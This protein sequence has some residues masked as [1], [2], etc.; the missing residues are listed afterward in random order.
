MLTE[1]VISAIILIPIAFALLY[2]GGWWFTALVALFGLIAG[3]EAYAMLRRNGYVPFEAWGLLIVLAFI[4]LSAWL[5]HDRWLPYLTAASI[6]GTLIRAL[7][8]RTESPATDWA[9]TMAIAF[10]LGVLMHHAPLLRAR[11]RGLW[12]VI[13]ALL[14]TWITDS[15]AYFIGTAA[16]RHRMAPRLSPKKTW[17]GTIGGWITGVAAA[18]LLV[19][20]LLPN[21]SLLQ[22][23]VLGAVVS[24]LAPL[25][26]L[27]ES[28][29]K[30][31]CGVK[32]S[33]RLIPG[34]GGALDRIDSLLFVFP[35][36]YWLS[37]IW[38]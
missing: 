12:W 32:D 25:G 35:A 5:P 14:L 24:T 29:F 38:G 16:G 20:A 7:A 37:V 23:A 28:M 9:I 10:Y 2:L 8:Q 19:P 21:L 11:P 3:H 15:G 6:M 30:R 22:A 34:H 4:V 33:G 26:D 36:V 18:L 1:R 13:T 31:Q 27:A 17:E